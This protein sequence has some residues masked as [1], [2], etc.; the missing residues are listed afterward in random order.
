MVGSAFTF[1]SKRSTCLRSRVDVRSAA[2]TPPR[3]VSAAPSHHHLTLTRRTRS[4]VG[5]LRLR[6]LLHRGGLRARGRSLG[7]RSGLRFG[8]RHDWQSVECAGSCH[9]LPGELSLQPAAAATS[10]R[11]FVEFTRRIW[12]R[13]CRFLTSAETVSVTS[14]LGPGSVWTAA[15]TLVMEDPETDE[16]QEP[17]APGYTVRCEGCTVCRD[18]PSIADFGCVCVRV[19]VARGAVG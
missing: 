8:V 4:G 6:C 14:T 15:V 18:F 10:A 3:S 13:G 16:A 7:R 11:P 17:E 1:S 19:C 2:T 5:G 12:L 9:L